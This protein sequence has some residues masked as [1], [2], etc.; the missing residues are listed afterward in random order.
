[1]TPA[2]RAR[3]YRSAKRDAAQ[4]GTPSRDESERHVTRHAL[5]RVSEIRDSLH[6]SEGISR[7][8][9]K[10]G[11]GEVT[12]ATASRTV[13]AVTGSVPT[14]ANL[15]VTTEAPRVGYLE[16][17]GELP[18]ALLDE[19]VD[20]GYSE[21][22]AYEGWERFR[23]YHVGRL[24][25]MS[26]GGFQR[27]YIAWLRED[28]ARAKRDADS[29]RVEAED[30]KRRLAIRDRE[31]KLLEQRWAEAQRAACS[32]TPEAIALAEAWDAEEAPERRRTLTPAQRIAMLH[33]AP[34]ALPVRILSPEERA[35]IAG[36]LAE[37]MRKATLQ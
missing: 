31:S 36:E 19:A 7:E 4:L 13:T 18:E 21:D 37:E 3:K 34:D 16:D 10:R 33:G 15:D 26:A 14:C 29:N 6:I 1:M 32:A 30:E 11:E 23:D 27:A 25:R 9:E 5:A 24:T 22:A 12:E 17:S 20:A 2:E 35:A 28:R 8:S